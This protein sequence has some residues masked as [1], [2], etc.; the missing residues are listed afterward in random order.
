VYAII[1]DGGKQ[2]KVQPGEVVNLELRDLP[3]GQAELE[4]DRVLLCRDDQTTIVGKPTIA[5]ASVTGKVVNLTSG[6]KLFPTSFKRRKDSQRRMG[7]RQK[8]LAVEITD[9]KQG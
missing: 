9:I 7:H 1:E 4:F 6:P 5:G 2:Y 8:Y 3:E